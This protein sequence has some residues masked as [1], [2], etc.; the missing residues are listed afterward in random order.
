[1]EQAWFDL[2]LFSKPNLMAVKEI[3]ANGK[4]LVGSLSI[5]S[6]KPY[7]CEGDTGKSKPNLTDMKE[8]QAIEI[9]SSSP[10]LHWNA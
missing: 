6:T 9:L 7:G 5:F 1:M 3:Q 8:I 10:V 2:Y 4:G